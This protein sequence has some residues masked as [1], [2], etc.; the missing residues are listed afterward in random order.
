M[1]KTTL[2]GAALLCGSLGSF[3]AGPA[4]AVPPGDPILGPDAPGLSA[5]EATAR[6]GWLSFSQIDDARD[7]LRVGHIG[8]A[9]TLTTRAQAG[10]DPATAARLDRAAD[11]LRAGDARAADTELTAA[12][13][14]LHANL[15]ALER[16]VD[17]I[18]GGPVNATSYGSGGSSYRSTGGGRP[19]H[20][21]SG[22]LP[23]L[24]AAPGLGAVTPGSGPNSSPGH[25]DYGSTVNNSTG[26]S[27]GR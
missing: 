18:T 3:W 7:A 16:R 17:P 11:A 12:Q 19:Q 27:G 24:G 14:G 15:M 6:H 8:Q 22:G 5:D 9:L 10:A 20:Y 4:G 1:R 23:G 25:V 26:M 13:G 2:L 21:G